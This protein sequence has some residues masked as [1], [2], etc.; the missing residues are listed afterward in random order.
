MERQINLAKRNGSLIIETYTLL[1]ILEKYRNGDM[2][3]K[4]ILNRFIESTGVLSVM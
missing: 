2:S 3:R 4:E 1:Q